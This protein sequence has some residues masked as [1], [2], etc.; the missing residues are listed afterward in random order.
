VGEITHIDTT[1]DPSCDRRPPWAPQNACEPAENLAAC[2]SPQSATSTSD[3]SIRAKTAV[4]AKGSKRAR[5]E[6]GT[7]LGGLASAVSGDTRPSTNAGVGPP[8][9]GDVVVATSA[10]RPLAGSLL[11]IGSKR[12]PSA[13]GAGSRSERAPSVSLMLLPP[14]C[15]LRFRPSIRRGLASGFA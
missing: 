7:G 5:R 9:A 10:H 14:E 12:R 2:S 13:S 11:T 1:N 3:M 15:H 8:S 4:L 6:A